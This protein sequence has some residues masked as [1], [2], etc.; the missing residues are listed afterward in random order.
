MFGPDHLGEFVTQEV[1][2][3]VA[4]ACNRE[5]CVCTTHPNYQQIMDDRIKE[6]QDETVKP[7]TEDDVSIGSMGFQTDAENANSDTFTGNYDDIVQED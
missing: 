6:A 4:D 5:F 1:S 2:E 7:G 3:D